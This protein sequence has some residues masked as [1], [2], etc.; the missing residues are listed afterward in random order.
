MLFSSAV[1]GKFA[2]SL[3]QLYHSRKGTFAGQGQVFSMKYIASGQTKYFLSIIRQ[4]PQAFASVKGS[5]EYPSIIGTVTFYES[6][7]GVLIMADIGGLPKGDPN[8][9]QDSI[10]AFHIH[11]GGSC[12]GNAE[13][14]FADTGMHWNPTGCPHPYHAGDL[15]PLFGNNG[16]AFSVFLSN[17]FSLRDVIGKTVVLHRNPDDFH[18]QPSGNSGQK[19]ACGVIRSVQSDS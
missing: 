17:R 11:E 13:D 5:A 14:L 12:T 19:I 10:F 7:Y 8:S 18:T 15:P 4:P 9:C 2:P 6:R 1:H 16:Y 3:R